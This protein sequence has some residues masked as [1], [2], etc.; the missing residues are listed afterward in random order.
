MPTYLHLFGLFWTHTILNH[1]CIGTNRY[2]QE[3]DGGKPKGAMIGM[4]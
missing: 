3:D 4:I 2:A 1:I